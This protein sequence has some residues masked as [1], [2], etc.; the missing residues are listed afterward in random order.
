MRMNKQQ[1]FIV[2]SSQVA[3]LTIHQ[4][5]VCLSLSS[6]KGLRSAAMDPFLRRR[7]NTGVP[8]N[9]QVYMGIR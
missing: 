4:D 8:E 9:L 6:K 5:L 2:S 1:S 7:T 3:T